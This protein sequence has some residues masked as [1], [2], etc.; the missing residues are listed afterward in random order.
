MYILNPEIIS[1]QD[2]YLCEDFKLVQYLIKNGIHYI[3]KINNT[4]IF[5]KSNRFKKAIKEWEGG[6]H[7]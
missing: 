1:D 3:S 7:M 4:W 2:K 6:E 5:I